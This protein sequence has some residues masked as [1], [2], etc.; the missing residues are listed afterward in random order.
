MDDKRKI[1][2][3][4][5]VRSANASRK[6]PVKKARKKSIGLRITI[7]K[8][9]KQIKTNGSVV[10]MPSSKREI[11]KRKRN[12]NAIKLISPSQTPSEV[13]KHQRDSGSLLIGKDCLLLYQLIRFS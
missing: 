8:Q 6:R 11:N 1:L 2:V 12:T 13:V 4:P 9:R 7:V 10:T 3:A 5:M